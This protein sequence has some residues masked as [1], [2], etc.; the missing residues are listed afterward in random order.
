MKTLERNRIDKEDVRRMPEAELAALGVKLVNRDAFVLE[1]S[2]CG[3]RWS[4]QLDA[5]GKLPFDAFR[6]PAHC[7][8]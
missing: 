7:N 8:G 3:E 2:R 6:C 1:C 4:P 5:Y